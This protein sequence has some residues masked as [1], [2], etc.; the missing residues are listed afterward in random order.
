MKVSF[1]AAWAILI[2]CA[3]LAPAQ[4][5]AATPVKDLPNYCEV[6]PN[7]GG[8]GQPTDQGFRLLAEKGYQVIINLRA[9]GEKVDLAAEEKLI[10]DLGMKYV[11]FP[12]V[13]KDA[14]E[15]LALRFM[16]LLEDVKEQKVYVHCASGNRVGS[17]L[18]VDLVLKQGMEPQKAEEIAAKVGLTSEQLRQYAR[19][20]IES[21]KK[22]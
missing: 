11:P 7:L 16:N 14:K 4:E 9:E 17:L 22:Q 10:K 19:Q 8:G 12:F 21:Q 5:P 15:D 18:M 6:L 2:L 3:V 20:V 1:R 13:T